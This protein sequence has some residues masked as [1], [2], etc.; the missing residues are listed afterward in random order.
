MKEFNSSNTL[1]VPSSVG[2]SLMRSDPVLANKIAVSYQRLAYALWDRAQ[3]SHDIARARRLI[4]A[5]CSH[6]AEARF[7]MGLGV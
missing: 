6:Y 2:R 3:R 1:P 4:D 7:I 5:A